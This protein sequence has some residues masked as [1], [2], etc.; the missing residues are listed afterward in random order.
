[1]LDADPPVALS[2][3]LGRV[4]S[5]ERGGSRGAMAERVSGGRRAAGAALGQ[6]GRLGLN[7]ES[8]TR[9]K[10]ALLQRME[11]IWQEGPEW[12]SGVDTA[13]SSSGRSSN[14]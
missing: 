5:I 6:L 12:Q 2:D 8:E 7:P 14:E 10:D 4:E 9:G 1:M 3:V 13:W 11:A